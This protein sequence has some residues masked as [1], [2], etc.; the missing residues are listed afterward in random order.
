M[1]K[2]TQKSSGIFVL[3]GF[4]AAVMIATGTVWSVLNTQLNTISSTPITLAAPTASTETVSTATKNVAS[5]S[6]TTSLTPLL[7]DSFQLSIPFTVQ[8][9]FAVWDALHEDTCEE[10]SFLMV[11][12]SLD[13]TPIPPKDQVDTQLKTMVD[14]ETQHGYGGSITLSQ[15]QDIAAQ[16]YGITT[17]QVTKNITIDD[18]K[19]QIT[20]G[21]SV[22]LGMAGKLLDNPYFSNGGPNYHALVV[23]GYDATGFITNDPGSRQGENFHYT[24]TNFYNAIHDW[25][26]TNILNGSKDMLVF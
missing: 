5:P 20:A 15:L 3:L 1:K 11:K 14:W 18:I 13:G 19:Q 10:A 8:A 9:P 6:P 12:Y 23:T 21:H 26:A 24:Y 4:I 17:G 16:E 7:P 25:D 2:H 22:I